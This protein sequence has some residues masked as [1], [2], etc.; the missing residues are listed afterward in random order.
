MLSK[1]LV[2][3]VATTA[4]GQTVPRPEWTKYV[5]MPVDHFSIAPKPKTFKMKV[6]GYSKYARA[7]GPIFFYSGNEGG[8]DGFWNNTGLPFDWAEEFGAEVI[9]AEHRYYGESLPFG[10]DSF[11][12]NEQRQYLRIEQAMQDYADF[13]RQYQEEKKT[14]KRVMVFGGKRPSSGS[15][16]K[17][18]RP[19]RG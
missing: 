9:M 11:R 12:S 18:K 10:E 13:I 1:L 6:L 17:R 4:L 16:K 5:D 14:T 15:T 8:I 3:T 19:P 2:A 7:D